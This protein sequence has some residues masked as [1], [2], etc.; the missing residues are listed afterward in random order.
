MHSLRLWILGV[1]VGSFAAGL[2]GGYVGSEQVANGQSLPIS[3]HEY[4]SDMAARYGL[5]TNQ[6]RS[7]GLVL[8]GESQQEISIL[9]NAQWSQLPP[10]VLAQLLQLR[11]VTE[12][13]IRAILD[14]EQRTHYDRDSRPPSRG[15]GTTD[16]R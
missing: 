13:R 15:S 12:R 5:R 6:K 10:P 14:D 4:A 16:K 9:K 1:A 2:V 3:D 11:S 7:L 8:Q